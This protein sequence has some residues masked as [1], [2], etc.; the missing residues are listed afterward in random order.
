MTFRA[1]IVPSN[2]PE[3]GPANPLLLDKLEGWAELRKDHAQDKKFKAD[4]NRIRDFVVY[5][6]NKPVN[7]YRFSDF[8]GLTD[9]LANSPANMSKQPTFDGMTRE[10]AALYNKGLSEA[11]R[12]PTL[13]AKAIE[14]NYLSPL[15]MF[16]KFT[17]AEYDFR[18]PLADMSQTRLPGEECGLWSL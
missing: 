18:S 5:A 9:V 14:A 11:H 10:Q 13:T 3:G 1:G 15:R 7:R 4:Q 6:G 12:F 2:V 17:A 16:F 8:Q